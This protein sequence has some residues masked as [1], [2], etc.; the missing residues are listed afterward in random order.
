M[1]GGHLTMLIDEHQ[2]TFF[3]SRPLA[4]LQMILDSQKSPN[5]HRANQPPLVLLRQQKKVGF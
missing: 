2:I 1:P 3:F 4:M 5:C